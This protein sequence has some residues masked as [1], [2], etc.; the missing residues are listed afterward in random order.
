MRRCQVAAPWRCGM[1]PIYVANIII[2]WNIVSILTI[3]FAKNFTVLSF[4]T[5]PHTMP[6]HRRGLPWHETN[7]KSAPP[8][9]KHACRKQWGIVC[10]KGGISLPDGFT[11]QPTL[12]K[13][14]FSA[15]AG[16]KLRSAFLVAKEASLCNLSF[17]TNFWGQK[18]SRISLSGI[19]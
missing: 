13:A 15:C 16:S 8:K 11:P 1:L 10:I 18:K 4:K 7:K 5:H 14:L 3:Y 9:K 17:F 2:I 6:A 12:S 19:A